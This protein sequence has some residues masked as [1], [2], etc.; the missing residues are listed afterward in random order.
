MLKNFE[1][2][3]IGIIVVISQTLY[4]GAIIIGFNWNQPLLS[5]IFIF[6]Q[7]FLFINFVIHII[8]N[9]TIKIPQKKSVDSGFEKKIAVIIPTWSEPVDMVKKTIVSIL[10][11]DYPKDKLL[12]ILSDDSNNQE[13]NVM[14]HSVAYSNPQTEFIYNVPP[15]KDSPFRKGEGKAGNLNSAFDLIKGRADIEFI[16]TRDADDLVG[17]K[18][19][20]KEMLGQFLENPK[21]GFAQSIKRVMHAEG[22]PF[23]NNQEVFYQ[24]VMLFK[25]AS[26]SAFPCGSG[27]L[28]RKA[29]LIDIGGFPSWNLVEDF[30]SGAEAL[31]RGWESIFVPIVGA[32]GQVCPED[33]PNHY[34]Q[35]GT[36]AMDSLRFFLWGNHRGL[37]F[38]QYLHF[39]ESAIAY[40]LYIFTYFYAFLPGVFLLLNV[41]PVNLKPVE[42]LLFQ[43]TQILSTILF[44]L[45]IAKKA[46][47]DITHIF[48]STQI[49]FGLFPAFFKALVLVLLYGPERKPK[50]KVT[51]KVNKYGFYVLMV[52]PQ[53]ALISFLIF[54]IVTHLMHSKGLTII[55][56]SNIFWCLY[57]I[58]MYHKVIF[59]SVFK[60]RP[61]ANN[62][63]K[64][65]AA[66]ALS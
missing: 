4:L 33:L 24:S 9:W 48:K 43:T 13:M 52:I 28:W 8:N 51:R 64:V 21:L 50:Y 57:F 60:W 45:A 12:I 34:K 17:H 26:N 31:R 19:F 30:Q 66:M 39:S 14:L 15:Q 22:D 29:A 35:R 27:L 65:E 44:S 2:R 55:D 40:L 62:Q 16:E 58:F 42:F 23:S 37:S 1:T 41:Q 20:L 63:K 38:R 53:I 36:W 61:F 46:N 49:D 56:F 25:N 6:F 54:S 59:N 10:N 7:L 18:T 47:V 11:Q 32:L 3:T 5:L